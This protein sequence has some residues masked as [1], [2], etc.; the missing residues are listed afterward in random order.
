M[1]HI[2]QSRKKIC[3]C[4]AISDGETDHDWSHAEQ[5]PDY[6]L[7]YIVVKIYYAFLIV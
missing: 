3:S 2:G 7:I 5:G 1:N 4:Q 6:L